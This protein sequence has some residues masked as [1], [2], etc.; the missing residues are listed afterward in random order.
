MAHYSYLKATVYY[1]YTQS[2]T[3]TAG[4]LALLAFLKIQSL[5]LIAYHNV[6]VF[7]SEAR[8]CGSTPRRF[9]SENKV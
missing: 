3:K 2:L 4:V 1:T 8:D 6:C 9:K 5:D 7:T